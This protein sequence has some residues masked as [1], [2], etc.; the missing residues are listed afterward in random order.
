MRKV[1]LTLSAIAAFGIALPVLSNP[2]A[3]DPVVVIHKRHYDHDWRWRHR[4]HRGAVILREH[5]HH[6]HDGVVIRGRF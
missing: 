2:A 5:R 6:D 1:I 3:A 4:E